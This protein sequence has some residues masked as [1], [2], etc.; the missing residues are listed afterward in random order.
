[1]ALTK[2]RDKASRIGRTA[3]ECI[4]PA[5]ATDNAVSTGSN[6]PE[7]VSAGVCCKKLER[8]PRIATMRW[9]PSYSAPTTTAP[10]GSLRKIPRSSASSIVRGIAGEI[11]MGVGERDRNR[12]GILPQHSPCFRD[13]VQHRLSSSPTSRLRTRRLLT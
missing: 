5:M 9:K 11:L 13:V 7:D 6:C 8:V 1:M 12:R 4:S 2:Q 3:P 10:F